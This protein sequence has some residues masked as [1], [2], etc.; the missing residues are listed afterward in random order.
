MKGWRYAIGVAVVGTIIS[1]VIDN[2]TI[3][4]ANDGIGIL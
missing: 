4:I 2:Y 3:I 1:W